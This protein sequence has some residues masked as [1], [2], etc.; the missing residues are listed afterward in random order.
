MTY[1]L[2]A[3]LT[4][5]ALLLAPAAFAENPSHVDGS[6]Q[7]GYLGAQPGAA[8]PPQM[9]L[10]PSSGSPSRNPG[11]SAQAPKPP[12]I[13]ASSPPTAFCD[14]ASI[15]PDRCRSRAADDHKMCAHSTDDYMSCRHTL[16]LFGWR[17]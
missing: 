13:D 3:I 6:G 17:L 9:G 10:L 12:T 4:L 2:A 14:A 15:E 8:I 1:R 7:G 5:G 16:D 11:M